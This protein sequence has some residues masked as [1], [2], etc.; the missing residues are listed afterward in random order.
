MKNI[1]LAGSGTYVLVIEMVL[2][3]FG[4]DFTDDSVTGAVNGLIVF[5]AFVLLVIGQ[6]RRK[7]LH[8]GL[9]R[10]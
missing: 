6:L 8:L 1:S 5:I 3:L 9:I 10:K 4:V 7:D 2:R